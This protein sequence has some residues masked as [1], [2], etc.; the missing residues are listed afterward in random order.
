M[1][2]DNDVYFTPTL[3][4]VQNRWHLAKHSELLDDPALRA[5]FNLY[6]PDALA[7]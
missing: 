7:G 4:I 5:A 2:L 3:S 6:N 1:S